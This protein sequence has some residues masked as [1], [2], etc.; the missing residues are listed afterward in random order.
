MVGPTWMRVHFAL[1]LDCLPMLLQ[2]TVSPLFSLYASF[3]VYAR[4]FDV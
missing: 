2:G 1:G 3:I 4:M